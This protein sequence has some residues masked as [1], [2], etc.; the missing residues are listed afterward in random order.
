MGPRGH[1][2]TRGKAETPATFREW[3]VD[4]ARYTALFEQWLCLRTSEF[5]A[6]FERFQNETT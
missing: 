3:R 6:A 4:P 1:R 5:E 2:G